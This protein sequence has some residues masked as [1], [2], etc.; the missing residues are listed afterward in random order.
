MKTIYSWEDSIPKCPNIKKKA[1]WCDADANGTLAAAPDISW[2][3][4]DAEALAATD[5]ALPIFVPPLWI[6]SAN[7]PRPRAPGCPK[8][9]SFGENMI[10][11][12]KISST[13]SQIEPSHGTRVTQ[14]GAMAQTSRDEPKQLPTFST[15][16]HWFIGPF[17]GIQYDSKCKIHKFTSESSSSAQRWFRVGYEYLIS[18][19]IPI[20]SGCIVIWCRRK[21]D[22]VN[23]PHTSLQI[24]FMNHDTMSWYKYNVELTLRIRHWTAEND[25][26]ATHA[27]AR[28]QPHQTTIESLNDCSV[29]KLTHF[30]LRL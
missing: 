23:I 5:G 21:N 19:S 16:V 9:V 24:W 20:K 29:D 11:T 1:C 25:E 22:H 18:E 13:Q 10:T 6:W 8:A 7:K 12:A 15:F 3:V 2:P 27:S 28:P 30:N 4:V 14:T 17:I 26:A